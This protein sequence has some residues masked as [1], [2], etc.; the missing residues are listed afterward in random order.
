MNLP[1]SPDV[2][3]P[4]RTSNSIKD[5][6]DR[7]NK[8]SKRIRNLKYRAHD[9]HLKANIAVL[10]LTFYNNRFY[11]Y[12]SDP[13]NPQRPTQ[14]H[15]GQR[16]YPPPLVD[17]PAIAAAALALREPRKHEADL[18]R[19]ACK[20]TGHAAAESNTIIN[21]N[22]SSDDESKTTMPISPSLCSFS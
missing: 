15:R 17:T 4:K 14:Y 3:I 11:V 5:D 18:R 13:T 8:V 6:R 16:S 19:E 21:E 7:K 10:L 1:M 22:K 2:S 9:F 12:T 20:R